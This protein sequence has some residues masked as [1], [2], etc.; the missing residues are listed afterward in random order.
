MS[1]VDDLIVVTG[2]GTGLV[3]PRTREIT[4]ALGRLGID[5]DA[6]VLRC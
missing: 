6:K 4:S 2:F 1:R 5:A 3:T